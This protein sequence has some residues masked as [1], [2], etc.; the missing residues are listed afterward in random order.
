MV[1]VDIGTESELGGDDPREL[2]AD[3]GVTNLV[4]ATTFIANW[5]K[6]LKTDQIRLTEVDPI[7]LSKVDS[8]NKKVQTALT[9]WSKPSLEFPGNNEVN[10]YRQAQLAYPDTWRAVMTSVANTTSTIQEDI[11]DLPNL[12]SH[13]LEGF[14]LMLKDLINQIWPILLIAGILIGL[15][16]FRKQIFKA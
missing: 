7:T 1:D 9:A 13:I 12:P 8:T 11:E 4:R 15:Y 2:D 6:A 16:I 3:E 10:L 5:Y 14:W